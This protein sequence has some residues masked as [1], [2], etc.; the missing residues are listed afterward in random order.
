MNKI[1][2]GD[3]MQLNKIFF[4]QLTLINEKEIK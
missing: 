1:I 2:V 4:F 3:K